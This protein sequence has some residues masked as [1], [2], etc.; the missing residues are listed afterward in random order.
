MK[1]F[2]SNIPP[3]WVLVLGVLLATGLV[4]QAT[5]WAYNDALNKLTKVG[6]ERLTLYSG[7]L[8]E[9]LSRYGYLP[10]VLSQNS[11]VHILLKSSFNLNLVNRYL[12]SLN[13]E[14]GSDALYVMNAIGDTLA[15]S[16][17]QEP[18]TYV[19]KNYGFRP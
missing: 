16:N 10:Y 2:F 7:T 11:D 14:A 1:K 5:R 12:Q 4:W 8:H 3:I 9:A 19:G 17:W 13:S 15:A 18:F 6:G